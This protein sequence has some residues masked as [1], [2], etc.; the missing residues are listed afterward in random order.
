MTHSPVYHSVMCSQ[1]SKEG[2]EEKSDPLIPWPKEEQIPQK[3]WAL[4]RLS[5]K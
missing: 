3:C 4:E 5:N 1:A 2:E